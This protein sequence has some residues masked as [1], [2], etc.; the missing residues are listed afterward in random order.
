MKTFHFY[1]SPEG[2]FNAYP[3]TMCGK[4]LHRGRDGML[5]QKASD[6]NCKNCLRVFHARSKKNDSYKIGQEVMYAKKTMLCLITR[7]HKRKGK[8]EYVDLVSVDKRHNLIDGRHLIMEHVPVE[9][10]EDVKK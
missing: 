6:P 1:D 3:K 8:A 7:I 5:N 2:F 10:L 4:V 9:S